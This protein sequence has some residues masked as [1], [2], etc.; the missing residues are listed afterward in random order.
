MGRGQEGG[1]AALAAA[2][3]F[4]NP[5]PMPPAIL[6][7]TKRW[8]VIDK[9]AGLAVH[10]GPRTLES[11]EDALAALAPNRPPPT[12]VHRLDRDTSGCLLLAKDKAA[13][14]RLAALFAAGAV[15]KTYVA[16]LHRPPVASQGVVDVPL[17]KLSSRAAGWRIVPAP[18]GKPAT[19][20]WSILARHAGR[21]LVLLQP[22]TGRTH[23]LRVHATLLAPGCAI[24]G[25]R[26]YGSADPRG[27]LL[28]AWRLGFPDPWEVDAQT[29]AEAPW[30]RRFVEAGFAA[31]G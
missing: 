25:D 20:H 2:L 22:G 26:V 23:Q 9:P 8:L 7:E 21:A 30:P 18:A 3:T 1:T 11:L 17:G 4:G 29:A 24:V 16:V 10:P 27:M 15:T 13:H 28:H 14:R 5:A 6:L 12:P 31:P 19:T